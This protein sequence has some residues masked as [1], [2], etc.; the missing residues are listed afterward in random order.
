MH[1]RKKIRVVSCSLSLRESGKRVFLYMTM[2]IRFIDVKKKKKR[3]A[4]VVRTRWCVCT[5][6]S[7]C[8]VGGV[9]AAAADYYDVFSFLKIHFFC[10]LIQVVFLF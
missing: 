2:I 4:R 1:N 6:P 8:L 10:Q 7:F 5:P 9:H 3:C